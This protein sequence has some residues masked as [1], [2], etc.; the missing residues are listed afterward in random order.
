MATSVELGLSTKKA[1]SAA[2]RRNAMD[3]F[4]A[5]I[6]SQAYRLALSQLRDRDAALDAV[7]DAMIRLVQKYQHKPQEQWAPLFFRILMNRVRDDQRAA[8]RFVDDADYALERSAADD[9]E[10]QLAQRDAI[11]ALEAALSELPQRQR[12]AVLLRVWEG[13]NVA[14]TAGI[15]G[16]GEGSVKT[17]LSRAMNTLRDKVEVFWA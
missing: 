11:A 9:P 12:E 14:Q 2:A 16:C 7:Q 6:E 4:L 17:H 8:R 3:H 5:S 1:D 10:R 15:M 13:F